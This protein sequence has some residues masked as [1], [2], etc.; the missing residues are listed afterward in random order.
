M[1]G[2]K[3]ACRNRADRAFTLVELLG[4]VAIIGILIAML[5]PAVQA[6]REAA[7][8]AQCQNNVKQLGTALHNYHA[9][10]KSFPI[11]WGDGGLGGEYGHSWLSLILAQIE[12]K[13]IY[14]S[15]NFGGP[16]DDANNLLAAKTP[17]DTFHCPSDSH[18]GTMANQFLGSGGTPD[19]W[20]V[21][22]YKAVAGAN[23]GDGVTGADFRYQKQQDSYGGRNFD[24][25]NGLD[26]GDGLICRGYHDPSG[27]GS[28]PTVTILYR[29]AMFELRDGSSNTFAI[30]EALPELCAWS[31]WYSYTGSTATCAIPLNNDDYDKTDASFYLDE[32]N[33]LSFRSRH[34]GGSN[35]GM[36]D[37]SVQF[38]PD[39]IDLT[40]YRAL[41]TIDGGEIVKLPD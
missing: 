5:L 37:A 16:L 3:K 21:T 18:D 6:A 20:A 8:R 22:N 27:S 40:V 41:A 32:A 33:C 28:G 31:S 12:Q 1:I 26:E 11:N 36:G 25:Y 4:V 2:R 10:H 9:L 17:I 30:G 35:F 23:W 13:P 15:I 39:V 29:T 24:T 7:R 38:I 19:V 34:S 14:D